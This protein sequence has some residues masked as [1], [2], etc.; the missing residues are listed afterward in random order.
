VSLPSR[1]I[2]VNNSR[3]KLVEVA[4]VQL[5]SDPLSIS[6]PSDSGHQ[7]LYHTAELIC[8]SL[9]MLRLLI[10]VAILQLHGSRAVLLPA[11][12]GIDHELLSV[13]S[14]DTS[15]PSAP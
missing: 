7:T 9:P 3:R 4:G 15:R 13:R 14:R 5:Q 8:D 12:A 6:C 2:C 11:V 10:F 1:I